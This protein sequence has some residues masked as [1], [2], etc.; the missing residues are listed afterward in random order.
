MCKNSIFMNLSFWPNWRGK[1]LLHIFEQFRHFW[2]FF[3]IIYGSRCRWNYGFILY[4]NLQNFCCAGKSPIVSQYFWKYPCRKIDKTT[5]RTKN[6]FRILTKNK[7]FEVYQIK[8][9]NII[10]IN[11][12]K[13]KL[14]KNKIL[15]KNR[16][17]GQKS[18]FWTKIE[19]L[20]KNRNFG[21]KS[22]F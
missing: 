9:K 3:W 15:V 17:F 14:G 22:K 1:I 10:I 4:K 7:F 2:H 6:R 16:N 13:N 21:Q 8:Q 12:G 18:K 19:I 11:W 5:N 20:D